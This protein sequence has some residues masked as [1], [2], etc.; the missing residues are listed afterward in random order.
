[1][2]APMTPAENA[3]KENIRYL[4]RILG[5]VIKDNEGEKTFEAIEAIRQSAV[6][7][8]REGDK[9]FTHKLD[10]LLKELTNSQTIAVARAFSYFKHLVNIAEDLYSNYQYRIEENLE[11]PG[12]IANSM[13]SF[14]KENLDLKQIDDFFK[15]AL[16][17]P[18]LTAHPTE[19]Q[20]KSLLD[21]EQVISTLLADKIGRAH[22]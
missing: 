14:K 12:S 13:Q 17:S 10:G 21:T 4:G 16:I 2:N 20:R 9:E 8:H 15:T 7:F 18:V 11:A 3:L 1:M 19:V 22:V 6:K 5:E